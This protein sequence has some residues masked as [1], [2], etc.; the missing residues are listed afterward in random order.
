MLDTVVIFLDKNSGDRIGGSGDVQDEVPIKVW[1]A[2]QGSGCESL[3]EGIKR[4]M[5]IGIPYKRDV[6][7]EESKE[8]MCGGGIVRNEPSKKISFALETL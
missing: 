2:D 1:R 6:R 4:L 7:A 5:S 8:P 3:L